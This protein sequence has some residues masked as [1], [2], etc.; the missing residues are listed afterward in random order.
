MTIV[1][2]IYVRG[3][4]VVAQRRLQAVRTKA[5]HAIHMVV[6]AKRILLFAIVLPAFQTKSE[7]LSQAF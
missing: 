4:P 3:N 6:Y 7:Y 2:I 5:S 1:D